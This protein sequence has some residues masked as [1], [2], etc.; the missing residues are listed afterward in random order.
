MCVS[1]EMKQVEM[2]RLVYLLI[3]LR[4]VLGLIAYDCHKPE[5]NI[6]VISLKDVA[7]CPD[8][9]LG[10]ESQKR[11]VRV[12]QRQ[13]FEYAHVYVCLIEVTRLINH[14]GAFSHSSIVSGGILSYIHEVGAD[15]C[16]NIHWHQQYSGF[17]GHIIDGIKSN[18]TT[19]TSLT[20]AG[21]LSASGKCSGTTY[22]QNGQTWENV[23][24]T[25]A[26]K[27]TLTDYEARVKLDNNEIKLRNG[28]VCRY[29]DH[30]C[31]DAEIGETTW[32]YERLSDCE[33]YAILFD[34]HG[35]IITEKDTN[36]R[37]LVVEQQQKV[38]ALSLTRK[39]VNCAQM[40]WTTEHPTL[41]VEEVGDNE[42][43]SLPHVHTE[44]VNLMIYA[45]S[46]FLYMEQA[47]GRSRDTLLA[48]TVY[49][50]CLLEREILKNRLVLA[51][52]APNTISTMIKLE[53]GYVGHIAGEVL[54]ILQC[55]PRMAKIRRDTRC[56]QELPVMVDNETYFVSPITRILQKHAVETEC[57]PVV[58]S[59]YQ[60]ENGDWYGFTPNPT[61]II[62][63]YSLKPG[64]ESSLKFKPLQDL[65]DGGIYTNDELN[66][67]QQAMMFGMER[68]TVNN[69][70]LSRVA[71][72][73]LDDQGYSTLSIFNEKELIELSKTTLKRLWG[74]M[75][76][77]GVFTSGCLGI[78]FIYR[79][80]KSIIEV[81]INGIAIQKEH[82]WTW[83]L[84]A[85]V[86]DTMTLW[87]IHRAQRAQ[88]Q[89][90]DHTKEDPEYTELTICTT[91][92]APP[93]TP[94]D[95]SKTK[96][97]P[98]QGLIDKVRELQYEEE[99]NSKKGW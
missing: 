93:S 31:M 75:E 79:I 25:A 46:K 38:F 15:E 40:R 24:V 96:T 90:R 53:M 97:G 28:I 61:R 9:K 63:P 39:S 32:R 58:P 51:Q 71:G 27:I 94:T 48:H 5:A 6:T 59:M 13:N 92:S 82:G 78:Y 86:W 26:I 80:A 18:S 83:H 67:A 50:R 8:V 76:D 16:M 72:K 47:L 77:I 84:L 2:L 45:N 44:D 95:E 54:Y 62:T 88:Q 68:E 11:R 10:Y 52:F 36:K 98:H 56:Y 85:S 89:A 37:F 57:S 17:S 12:L 21:S 41:V 66:S 49:R 60:L 69:I 14:C 87:I 34:G 7:E 20:L 19:R 64:S 30:Y 29:T 22:T 73:K 42:H 91:P 74:W 23:I 65:G 55:V 33:R 81:V 70:L 43:V 1:L 4:T 99:K 3:I 35:D